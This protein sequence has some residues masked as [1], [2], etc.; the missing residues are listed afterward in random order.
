MVARHR[1]SK[2][3]VVQVN[4]DATVRYVTGI[5]YSAPKYINGLLSGAGL[6]NAWVQAESQLEGVKIGNYQPDSLEAFLKELPP[7]EKA[8]LYTD[9]TGFMK[10][11]PDLAQALL[12]QTNYKRVYATDVAMRQASYNYREMYPTL[13]KT[14]NP[15]YGEV[16]LSRYP[17]GKSKAQIGNIYEGEA[18]Y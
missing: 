1:R 4:P 7:S 14:K 2:R 10:A 11:H 8:K 13:L 17:Q 5:L 9:P 16:I 3:N 15:Q 6:Y 18:V 12:E